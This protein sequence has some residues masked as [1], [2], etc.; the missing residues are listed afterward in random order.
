MIRMRVTAQK[1]ANKKIAGAKAT[2]KRIRPVKSASK[3]TGRRV[4]KSETIGDQKNDRILANRQKKSIPHIPFV[5]GVSDDLE[6]KFILGL[7]EIT[8]E[9]R[10]DEPENLPDNYG[11][12]RLVLIARD[13]RW[14]FCYWEIDP[15]IMEKGLR[16]LGKN[17][18]QT[19]W[20]LRVY[21]LPAGKK[22]SGEIFAELD[23]DYFSGKR[24][25]ELFPPG[26]TFLAE[27]GLMDQH[28]NFAAIVTSNSINLP[29]DRPSEIFEEQWTMGENVQKAFNESIKLQMEKSG[30]TTGVKS[31]QS[32]GPS[33]SSRY[34]DAKNG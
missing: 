22:E 15:A 23:V 28:K 34:K 11:D 29:A 8:D 17:S 7:P 27:L 25:L 4:A 19:H 20:K 14:A 9:L 6:A 3:K 32:F 12:H 16:K 30:S 24:Y 5:S 21:R 1:S 31:A 13:P 26:T 33:S 2:K 18:E 10:E